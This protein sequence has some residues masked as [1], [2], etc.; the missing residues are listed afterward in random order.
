MNKTS[1]HASY[2]LCHPIR[3]HSCT[4]ILWPLPHRLHY[5]SSHCHRVSVLRPRRHRTNFHLLAKCG[6]L[7]KT[8][9]K[10]TAVRSCQM[11]ADRCTPWVGPCS[12][13]HSQPYAYASLNKRILLHRGSLGRHRTVQLGMEH[14][15]APCLQWAQL[16]WWSNRV[17]H[18]SRSRLRI[19]SRRALCQTRPCSRMPSFL[20]GT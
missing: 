2:S 15:P 18:H 5:H 4:A 14:A 1:R 20:Q 12:C 7:R 10:L 19:R 8:R 6:T 17:C 9:G 3:Y 11:R 13:T 16:V